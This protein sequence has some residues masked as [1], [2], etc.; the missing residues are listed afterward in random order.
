MDLVTQDNYEIRH[1][2]SMM[3]AALLE[4]REIKQEPIQKIQTQNKQDYRKDKNK[5]TNTG[6]TTQENLFTVFRVLLVNKTKS[7]CLSP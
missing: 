5:N 4:E 1:K 6:M 3:P 2:Q 7:L